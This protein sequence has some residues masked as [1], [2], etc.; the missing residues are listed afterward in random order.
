M[1]AETATVSLWVA[2]VTA[3]GSGAIGASL[4]AF[5]QG[6]HE[7]NESWRERVIAAALAFQEPLSDAFGAYS[8]AFQLAKK[9]DGDA[10]PDSGTLVSRD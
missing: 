7:R 10:L 5:L 2:L 4:A 1:L 3:F 9:K 8:R 6:R